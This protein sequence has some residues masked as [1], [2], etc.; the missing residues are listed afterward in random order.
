VDHRLA[1]RRACLDHRNANV[2]ILPQASRQHTA[3]RT[4]PTIT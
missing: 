3:G 4:G 2:A 1:V